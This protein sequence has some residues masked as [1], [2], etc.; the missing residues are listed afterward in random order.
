MAHPDDEVLGCGGALAR[1]SREGAEVFI[2]ILGEGATSR[3]DQ[4]DEADRKL[5]EELR[6]NARK[7]GRLLGASEVFLHGLPDNRF[8]T[9]P[10]LDIIKLVEA[11]IRETSPD[12]IF[13][14]DNGDLN[15][16]HVITHRS[17][18]T[19]TRPVGGG[20]VVKEIFSCEIP[21]STEWAFGQFG[22]AFCPNTFIDIAQ[23]IMIKIE[24][25]NLYEKESRPSPH[26]RAPDSLEAWARMR[27]ATASMQFAEAFRLIRSVR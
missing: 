14:H 8:D 27:G 21:S 10:L 1:Y 6:S 25:M 16:D 17:V 3:F 5:L 13:T 4:R 15:M 22:G 9:V 26:P 19:A 23:G 12:I 20:H 11:D 7:A 24:A 18:L 2:T